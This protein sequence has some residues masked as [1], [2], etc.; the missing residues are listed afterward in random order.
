MIIFLITSNRV[1]PNEYAAS[2]KSDGTR[3]TTS[4]PIE[5]EKGMTM[6]E[7]IKEAVS[8]PTPWGVTPTCISI[9]LTRGMRRNSPQRP[10][11]T[12]GIPARTSTELL[13]NAEIAPSLKYSP[14]KMEMKIEKGIDI[15]S[16]RKEVRSV[17]I[18]KGS[19][20]N[21]SDATS[22]VFP[23]KN[24]NPKVFIDGT[25][26]TISVRQTTIN[27]ATTE[28]AVIFR[29]RSNLFSVLSFVSIYSTRSSLP[30]V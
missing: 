4:L 27:K 20:P 2:F 24:P 15:A 3:V 8:I 29:I 23:I 7:S 30:L 17:P 12:E 10:K 21:F 9:I 1:A 25:E 19:A 5:A 28:R 11:I 13:K 6:I 26:A 22:H 16:A 14:R 18:R